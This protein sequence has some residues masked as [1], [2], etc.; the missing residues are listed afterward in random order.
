MSDRYHNRTWAVI[1]LS[2]AVVQFIICLICLLYAVYVNC[3]DCDH[4]RMISYRS[5]ILTRYPR[6]VSWCT[7]L[8]I[9]SFLLS[10]IFQALEFWFRHTDA[11][12]QIEILVLCLSMFWWSFGQFAS[13]L[14]F[15]FRLIDVFSDC[16][17]SA[18][19]ISKLTIVYL[20]ILAILYEI[21]WIIK[22]VTGYLFFSGFAKSSYILNEI[23]THRQL[24]TIPVVIIE[25]V[26]SISMIY[27]FV[28]RLFVVMKNQMRS[29]H[30]KNHRVHFTHLLDFAVKITSLSTISLLSSFV[31]YVLGAIAYFNDYR[32]PIEIASN[33]CLQMHTIIN[34]LVL[35][36]FLESSSTLY[37]KIL[38]C[39]CISLCA[40]LMRNHFVRPE[41]MD[42]SASG[43]ALGIA[44]ASSNTV[45]LKSDRPFSS[46]KSLQTLEIILESESIE[47]N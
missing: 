1:H 25:F 17:D 28:S 14:V 40:P 31:V 36:L 30:H 11:F 29:L 16:T 20:S 4:V 6:A 39:C 41:L 44:N 42:R 13:Y 7:C 27:H 22:C 24:T 35:V 45:T 32:G 18:V 23:L 21:L 47:L 15:I 38:C 8:G 12:P 43:S 5:E 46:N 19:A 37:S 10:S 33:L 26:I 9:C 3:V 2:I 34:C